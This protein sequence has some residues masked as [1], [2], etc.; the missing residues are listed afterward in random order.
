[1]GV[2]TDPKTFE[3]VPQ[4]M[5]EQRDKHRRARRITAV[6]ME[7]HRKTLNT[8]WT[9]KNIFPATG[10]AMLYGASNVGKSFLSL[11]L[12]CAVAEGG[13]WFGYPTLQS[14][15][16]YVACEGVYGLAS[17]VAAWRKARKRPMPESLLLVTDAIEL[18]KQAD[19]DELVW[20]VED[21]REAAPELPRHPV[22]IIDT[23]ASAMPGVDENSSTEM[24]RVVHHVRELA[25]RTEGLVLLVHHSGKDVERGPRGHSLLL[26][27]VD[28]SVQVRADST[29]GLR[30]WQVIKSRD[31]EGGLR[32][33]FGLRVVA[34]RGQ[35]GE[36]GGTSCVVV[37][38]SEMIR[39][40]RRKP[41][42][43]ASRAGA[44]RAMS[45]S[46]R[47][48]VPS[49]H[50]S[51]LLDLVDEVVQDG[52]TRVT[53]DELRHRFLQRCVADLSPSAQRAAWSRAR[54]L[55]A[56]K[57]VLKLDGD[58]VELLAADPVA[59]PL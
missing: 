51:L 7:E 15:V 21:L 30:E 36:D 59:Y 55:L 26:A 43:K 38:S 25:R 45:S 27:A 12:A 3:R 54:K 52:K 33:S 23:L 35:D 16:I 24:S 19:A 47:S 34:L 10:V 41:G 6:P 11:D 14:T 48:P 49:G 40:D 1:M 18:S 39:S 37:P 4:A 9:V 29:A 56:E 2:N 28:A 42:G 32:A 22:F 17:R 31:G 46:S 50:A 57:G 44:G 13:S 53:V 5:T 58:Y 8:V 20:L